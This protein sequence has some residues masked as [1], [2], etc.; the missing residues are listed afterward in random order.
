LSSISARRA[1]TP[2]FRRWLILAISASGLFLICV[3][4]TVLYVALP[5]LTRDLTAS[6][7]QRLW[8]LNAYPIVVAGLLPGLGTLG[9]RH[10]HRLLF[11]CGLLTFGVASLAAAYAPTP[12]IL[13]IARAGLG[14]GAAMMMPATLAIIRTTFT[15]AHERTFAIG[16][17]A[18]IAAGGMALGP[19]IAGLLLEKFWWGSVFLINV[20]V[21]AV[22]LLAALWLI[23]SRVAPGGAPWDLTGSLQIL[24]GLTA[25]VFAIK[26][27][28][29][30][31]LSLWRLGAAAALGAVF[32]AAYLRHQRT[33]AQ[34]LLDLSLFRL[35]DF[36]GAFAAACLGT[37]GAVG[38]E[39]ALSQYLQLVEGRSALGAAVIFLPSAIAGF[40]SGPLAG[41]L[42]RRMWPARLACGAFLLAA[43]CILTV[44]ALPA[45]GA[46]TPVLRLL[47]IAGVGLG[48]G[49]T[50]TFAS[51]TIMG[52]APP[53]RGG[54]AASIEEVGFELGN[55]LG[56]AVF[57]SIMTLAYAWTL[58]LPE[59]AI[60]PA[61]VRDSL[62]EAL[63]AAQ[64]LPPAVAARLRAAGSVAFGHALQAV[65]VGVGLLWIATGIAIMA[66]SPRPERTRT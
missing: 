30:Q 63:R 51:S 65:L 58:A 31:D 37:S 55:S 32:I 27:L 33:R 36:G 7:S 43:L 22:A 11:A 64:S 25:V 23:P 52:V 62:D 59:A 40:I 3:D 53:D 41:R 38:L 39:L 9:D 6:N 21:V 61:T 19:V 2:A 13:I 42:M 26:E 48:I 18:G 12:T 50:V 46:A 49:A 60:V 10:G 57:G 56:V 8:I 66:N 34:P 45:A 4:L 20:P 54:M 28:A 5:A 15:D 47:L 44:A 17:W 1:A 29:R 16:L 14:V 24:I 35:P